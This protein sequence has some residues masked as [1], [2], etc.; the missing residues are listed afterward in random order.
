[1]AYQ[2]G[3]ATDVED[4]MRKFQAFAQTLGFGVGGG[5][6]QWVFT[7]SDGKWTFEYKSNILFCHLDN[8]GDSAGNSAEHNYRKVKTGSN[9]LNRGSYSAYHFFGTAQYAHCV[10]DLDG[11]YFIHFGIG[12]LNKQGEYIGGQ[13]AYGTY[14]NDEV[15]SLRNCI[16]FNGGYERYPA[17]VRAEGISGDTRRP[18]YFVQ[19]HGSPY[20]LNEFAANFYG[21]GMFSNCYVAASGV[22]EVHHEALLLRQSHSQF[23]NLIIPV[24]NNLIVVGIDKVLRQIG[25]PPDFYTVRSQNIIAGQEFEVAGSRWKMFPAMRFG[26]QSE[27]LFHCYRLI[28]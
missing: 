1:M 26:K 25:S 21:G 10:V 9:Y 11:E 2:T 6:G 8:T 4:L 15:P 20:Y 3:S 18:W 16:A 19:H 28:N 17:V 22:N 27:Y 23:G 13:Y 5:V 24:P 7:N 12:T 14:V